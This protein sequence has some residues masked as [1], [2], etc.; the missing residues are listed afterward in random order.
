MAGI[1]YSLPSRYSCY[2][3]ETVYLPGKWRGIKYTNPLSEI[4]QITGFL[5]QIDS[6]RIFTFMEGFHPR[7]HV[8]TGME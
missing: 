8:G 1:Q 7:A 6:K 3:K 2:R 5:R 4:V